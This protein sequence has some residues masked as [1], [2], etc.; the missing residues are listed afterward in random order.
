MSGYISP[1]DKTLLAL[2]SGGI[3][4]V[5]TCRLALFVDGN[6]QDSAKI[7]GEVAHIKG[8]KLGAARYDISQTDTERNSYANLIYLC[9]N[10]HRAID[11]QRNSYTVEILLVMKREHETWIKSSTAEALGAVTF[12]ELQA[13]TSRILMTPSF[14]PI[15][16]TITL[17]DEK[18][19]KNDLQS[20]RDIISMGLALESEVR[21]Y[22]EAAT[23]TDADFLE[24]LKSGFLKEYTKHWI[25]GKRGAALFDA[26][27]N[28]A[29]GG[30]SDFKSRA[31]GLAVL[32]YLFER[33]EVFDP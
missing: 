17:P 15:S 19:I 6:D 25:A 13:V 32:S 18:I 3:C 5:P 10:C 9:R 23:I 14:T 26:L 29:S 20:V 11:T 16:F 31:A 2:R 33:C 12:V 4:A 1:T 30:S 28:F 8:E 7:V 27:N 22:I 21:H 24:R